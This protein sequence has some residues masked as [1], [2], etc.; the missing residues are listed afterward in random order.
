MADKEFNIH[1]RT[2]GDPKG[3]KEVER[4]IDGAA[5]AAKS[6]GSSSNVGADAFE[7]NLRESAAAAQSTERAVESLERSIEQLNEEIVKN[8]S[9]TEDQV[10]NLKRVTSGGERLVKIQREQRSA[11]D[12]GTKSTRNYGLAALEASRAFED[13]Q[14]GI[15]GVLNNIPSLVMMLGGSAGLTAVISIAAVT[16]T[17]LWERLVSGPKEAKKATEDWVE[18]LDKAQR[19]FRD[20]QSSAIESQGDRIADRAR[21]GVVGYRFR[22]PQGCRQ[23]IGRGAPDR[24]GEACCPRAQQAGDCENRVST[25]ERFRGRGREAGGT[26]EAASDRSRGH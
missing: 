21:R 2:T 12:A 26:P 8:K 24:S 25:V 1:L 9:L 11:A 19:V 20:L 22:F 6:L 18:A 14:Y 13:M 3:A 7:R 10:T 23:R 15:R 17:Q 16:A 5:D 4:A